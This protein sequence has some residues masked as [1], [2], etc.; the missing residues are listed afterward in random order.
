MVTELY[1]EPSAAQG[2]CSH[3]ARII[4]KPLGRPRAPGLLSI[5]MSN[6]L[7]EHP[8]PSSWL[9]AS[10]ERLALGTRLDDSWFNLSHMIYVK[11]SIFCDF[12]TLKNEFLSILDLSLSHIQLFPWFTAN[13]NAYLGCSPFLRLLFQTNSSVG[14]LSRHSSMCLRMIP[15]L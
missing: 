13:C 1:L 5:H 8:T 10:S 6:K 15:L 12:T 7:D 14:S 9:P 3:G 11:D 4:L 2:L